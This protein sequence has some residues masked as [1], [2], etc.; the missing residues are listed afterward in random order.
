MRRLRVLFVCVE[1][2]CRS[3]MAEAF[4]R[5]DGGEGVEAFSAGSRPSGRVNP[6]AVRTMAEVGYDLSTHRSQ[7]PADLPAGGAWDAVVTMGCGDACPAV[8]AARREDWPVPDPKDLHATS[9]TGSGPSWPPSGTRPEGRIRPRRAPARPWWPDALKR[10]P[11]SGRRETT[12]SSLPAGVSMPN[13]AKTKK[14]WIWRRQYVIDRPLQMGIAGYLAAGLGGVALLC[15]AA[16]YVFL[17]GQAVPGLDPLRRFLLVANAT[18]FILAA[19]ILT[20]LT[21]LLTHRFAGPAYVMKGAIDGMLEGDYGKRLSLRKKDYL[22]ELA[23]SIDQLRHTWVRHEEAS[24]LTLESLEKALASGDVEAAQ[25]LV[26][27]LQD[28]LLVRPESLPGKREPTDGEPETDA[29]TRS[30]DATPVAS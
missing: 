5:L 24:R 15:A 27:D 7:S 13:K 26:K 17:G 21:I 1:N 4:A 28:A 22:K 19:G 20:L 30:R 16:L 14:P 6:G 11:A 12:D 23:A 25:G 18:Y 3:Q 2:S 8:P 10:R 9:A 29:A